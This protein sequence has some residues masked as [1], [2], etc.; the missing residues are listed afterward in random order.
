[1]SDTDDD[2]IYCGMVIDLAA[3]EDELGAGVGFELQFL[4]EL[5]LPRVCFV[6]AP[7]MAVALR[8]KIEEL[9]AKHGWTAATVPPVKPRE[10]A[11]RSGFK[12]GLGEAN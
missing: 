10:Y 9:E 7:N 4:P 8:K 2:S 11:E 6:I 5:D 1:M 12:G 3:A